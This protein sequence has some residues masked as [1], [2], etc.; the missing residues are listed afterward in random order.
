MILAELPYS[1]E[2]ASG[3]RSVAFFNPLDASS[4]ASLMLEIIEG[5]L[6]SFVRVPTV[7]YS[8]PYSP[9]WDALFNVLLEDESLTTR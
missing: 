4:L 3:A 8:H 6:H 5:K 7:Q 1:H 9:T 2:S